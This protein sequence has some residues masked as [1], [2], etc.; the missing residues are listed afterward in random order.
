MRCPNLA[1]IQKY[2]LALLCRQKIR[3]DFD[4]LAQAE[5]EQ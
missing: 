3:L 5:V 2:F 4:W 1:P